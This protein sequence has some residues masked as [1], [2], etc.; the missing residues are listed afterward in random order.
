MPCTIG[1]LSSS[2]WRRHTAYPPPQAS[3]PSRTPVLVFAP[4][5]GLHSHLAG[6]DSS[7][8]SRTSIRRAN[9]RQSAGLLTHSITIMTSHHLHET[10]CARPYPVRHVSAICAAIRFGDKL[11]LRP[12]GWVLASVCVQPAFERVYVTSSVVT[13][14]RY[15]WSLRMITTRHTV[16]Y[17]RHT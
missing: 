15:R 1:M 7:L 5:S 17:S 9:S 6:V 2:G 12:E 8:T 14:K 10:G 3:R 11:A 13:L 4:P 16:V